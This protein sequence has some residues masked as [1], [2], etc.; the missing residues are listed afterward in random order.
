MGCGSSSVAPPTT[1]EDNAPT[2]EGEESGDV[3]VEAVE[4][5]EGQSVENAEGKAIE[6]QKS[7]LYYAEVVP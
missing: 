6:F 5:G 2:A 4:A 1:E 3:A 7:M